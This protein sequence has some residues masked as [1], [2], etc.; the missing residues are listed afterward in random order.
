M[1]KI[2]TDFAFKPYTEIVFGRDTETRAGELVRKYGGTKVLLVYGSGSIKKSGLYDRVTKSLNDAGLPFAEL[3]GVHANPR[4]SLVDKGIKLAHAEG[5]DFFLAVGGGSTIDT[6]KG[7]A[8]AMA[9]NDEYWSFYEHGVAPTA[10]APVGTIHTIAAAGSETSDSTVLVDDI[11]SG[12]KKGVSSEVNRPQ[13]AIFNPELTYTLSAY[14]TGA[15][16]ADIFAHT[17]MRYLSNYFS[18]IGDKYGVATLRTIVKYAPIALAKPEDYEARAQIMLAGAFSH[19]GL[20]AIGRED[21]YR[22]GEHQMEHQLSGHYD[23]AHGAG[24]SVIMP[25]FLRYIVKHGSDAQVAKVAQLGIEVFDVE[26]DAQDIAA[27][28]LIT[29]DRLTAWLKSIGMPTTLAELG[30]PVDEIND[31]VQR[32]VIDNG[33]IIHGFLELDEAAIAEVYQLAL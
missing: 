7:I 9:N 2:F 10:M 1:E 17:Y 20:T 8:I 25:A 15:G 11:H 16:S 12:L 19:S 32:A 30:V 26:V 29:A 13:F 31:M 6:A 3:G 4:R 33:G 21:T 22:G 28:A 18:Y 27:T 23:T 14:Q 5:V 24:L